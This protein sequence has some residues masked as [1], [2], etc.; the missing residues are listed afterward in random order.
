[1]I[2]LVSQQNKSF[3]LQNESNYKLKMGIVRRSKSPW[4]SSL[5]LVPKSIFEQRRHCGDYRALNAITKPGGLNKLNIPLVTSKLHGMKFFSK[6]DLFKAF[7]EMP[8]HPDDSV[9]ITIAT[10]VGTS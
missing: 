9:K 7:Q 3:P 4:E 10:S 6:V 1:M 5:Q 2:S 8:M